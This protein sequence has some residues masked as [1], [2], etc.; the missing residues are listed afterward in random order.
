MP[1]S[2][3]TSSVTP[4]TAKRTLLPPRRLKALLTLAILAVVALS[5]LD[6]LDRATQ[7][8][9]EGATTQ[10]LLA[11]AA[12]R[13]LNAGISVLQSTEMGVGVSTHPFE[14][15]DPFND[16][17]EDYASV[18]KLAIGSLI[19]QTLLL[20]ITGALMF[21]IALSLAGALLILCLWRDWRLTP[22]AW[23]AFGLIGTRP[24]SATADP[25]GQ[26]PGGPGLS[27]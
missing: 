13:G 3:P 7:R 17:V 14:A 18:M 6:V 21:K 1:D 10:A 12:A 9:V 23:K 26:H 5:W 25:G 2:A 4:P 22:M 16:L 27:R 8:Q 11:F 19:G 24:V 20:E 15:L